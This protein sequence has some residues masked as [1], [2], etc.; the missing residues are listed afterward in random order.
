MRGTHEKITPRLN[1]YFKKQ[2]EIQKLLFERQE[3]ALE[4]WGSVL[5]RIEK[6]VDELPAEIAKE[7]ENILKK[8]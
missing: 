1:D 6:L 8:T 5:S 7:L 2:L 4:D 3:S